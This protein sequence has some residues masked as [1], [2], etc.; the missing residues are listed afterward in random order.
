MF[1]FAVATW[2]AGGG[3]ALFFSVI[4]YSFDESLGRICFDI[5][6]LQA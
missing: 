2:G 4:D 3:G 5:F 1:W 6:S